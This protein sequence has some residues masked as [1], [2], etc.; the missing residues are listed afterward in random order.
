MAPA[1]TPA[2]A[3]TVLLESWASAGLTLGAADPSNGRAGHVWRPYRRITTLVRVF[4][5]EI[6]TITLCELSKLN[7]TLYA[8]AP[9]IVSL[10]SCRLRR[11]GRL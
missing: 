5:Q 8:V 11:L 4:L 7:G 10:E 1:T 2:P 3:Q 9:L 6:R